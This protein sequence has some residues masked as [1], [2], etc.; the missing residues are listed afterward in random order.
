MA[1]VGHADPP[2]GVSGPTAG[3][4]AW[5]GT[6]RGPLMLALMLLVTINVVAL[7]L[8]TS[9]APAGMLTLQLTADPATV[10]A[11]VASWR[12]TA[13][14]RTLWAHGLDLLFPFVAVLTVRRLAWGGGVASG[15]VLVAAVA[16]Q[17]ENVVTLVTLLGAVTTAGVRMTFAAATLKWA[18]YAVTALALGAAWDARRRR[19]RR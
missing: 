18:A 3:A 5:P 13:W 16:D 4:A 11:V 9:A 10:E 14:S 19:R 8:R 17:V 1:A 7:P 6:A 12:A 2:R 15:A